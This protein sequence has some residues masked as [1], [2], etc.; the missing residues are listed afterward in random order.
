[1]GNVQMRK[2]ASMISAASSGSMQWLGLAG[3]VC[4]VTGAGNGIGAET[5]RQLSLAGALVAVLD[6][7]GDAAAGVASD[8]ERVG[9]RVISVEAD[10]SQK[11]A[12][13]AAADRIQSALGPCQV[14]VNNAAA[15]LKADS[16]MQV[17]IDAWNQSIA[18]NLTGALICAQ[19]FAAQ[20]INGGRAGCI[21]NVASINGH[22]PFPHAGGYSVSKAGMLMMSKVLALE[23]APH[24]IRSNVVSP[25]FTLTG[26]NEK[27]YGDPDIAVG[28]RQLVPADRIGEPL[29]MANAIVFLASDRA[30]Y[31]NAQEILVDG[32]LS[33]TVM[34]HVP[35][36]GTAAASSL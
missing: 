17:D 3:R 18:V 26:R 10:V 11:A 12:V 7:D 16:L 15:V 31:I 29:D 6:R 27:A 23:L 2:V 13:S 30:S 22:F 33:Q 1:M 5:A 35:R 24:G 36:P 34:T 9:G 21:V 20:M 19:V 28:R 25:G 32:G 14:L 8:I 4:V